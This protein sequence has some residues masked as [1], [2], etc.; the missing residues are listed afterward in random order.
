VKFVNHTTLC[1]TLNEAKFMSVSIQTAPS[2][3]Q[4][5]NPF[6][7][8]FSLFK[9]QKASPT[10][11]NSNA[12]ATH[13]EEVQTAWAGLQN[14]YGRLHIA[15]DELE[16]KEG[17]VIKFEHLAQVLNL[18][19]DIIQDCF[20]TVCFTC[21]DERAQKNP[22]N[23]LSVGVPGQFCLE[24]NSCSLFA[25][26]ILVDCKAANVKKIKL[27]PHAKCGAATLAVKAEFE[28]LG[29]DTS[30]I[31]DVLIDKKAIDYA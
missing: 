2:S 20:D 30:N 16:A 4:N 23:A 29:W 19:S 7:F 10:T 9:S 26:K 5:T 24:K 12:H 15:L 25:K 8:I 11:Q 6:S 21:I 1:Y 3:V 18:P 27:M 22:H 14:S 31:P 28:D 17:D 13:Q